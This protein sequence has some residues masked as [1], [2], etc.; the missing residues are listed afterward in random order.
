MPDQGTGDRVRGRRLRWTFSE[1]P[2]TGKTYE[3]AFHDDGTL[4][5]RVVEDE[6]AD[7]P[8]GA[9]GGERPAYAAYALSESVELVSYRAESGFTL[10]VALN[11]ADHRMVAIA[12][13]SEQ[14]FPARGTFQMVDG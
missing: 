3:H 7:V 6:A 4:E 5:Y 10:T 9:P 2:Q 1:G 8:R 11:F 14:W 12:S 13:N